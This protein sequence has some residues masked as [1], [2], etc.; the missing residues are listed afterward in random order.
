MPTRSDLPAIYGWLRQQ[1]LGGVPGVYRVRQGNPSA[2]SVVFAM[3]HGKEPAGLAV[4]ALVRDNPEI[5]ADDVDLTVAIG[6]IDAADKYFGS[7]TDEERKA[8][9]FTD[10][11]MNRL[12]ANLTELESSSAREFRRVAC[13]RTVLVDVQHIFDVHST[14]PESE[15][16]G[17]VVDGDDAA[18]G[19]LIGRLPLKT[20]YA[21]ITRVQAVQGTKTRPHGAAYGAVTALEV[22][23]G[24]HNSSTG[25][26]SA[27]RAF[28]SWG[29]ALGIIR[30]NPVERPQRQDMYEVI[31]SYMA[32]DTSYRVQSRELLDMYAPV[33]KGDV[34]LRNE[35][36]CEVRAATDGLLI[37]G[38]D[39]LTLS[40][41]DVA[42]EVWFQVRLVQ[43]G[44]HA[45]VEPDWAADL[46]A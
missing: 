23:T 18:T 27:V 31:G 36:G 39:D 30:G 21:G 24:Q 26:L 3:T 14:D 4:A 1:T 7:N 20:V 42:S 38:P 46:R 41:Q 25:L 13:L 16:A 11:D 5:L 8:C 9:R 28:A 45:V 17:L 12:P 22:E 35:A 33:S 37:Y 6:N 43:A 2:R 40:P 44:L 32:P 29:L 15:T 10:R 34:L 19:S